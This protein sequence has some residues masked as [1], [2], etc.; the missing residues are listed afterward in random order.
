[1]AG[2]PKKKAPEGHIKQG[3]RVSKETLLEEQQEDMEHQFFKKPHR[4]P[5]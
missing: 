4:H 2:K 3:D 1:M 5:K